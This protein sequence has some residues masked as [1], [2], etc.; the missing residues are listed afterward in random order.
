MGIYKSDWDRV[1]GFPESYKYGW[2]GE[3][4][5]LMD[6]VFKQGLEYIR[7]KCP[8]V[9]HYNHDRKKMWTR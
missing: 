1:G 5:D 2:G 4:Y 3:D 7:I 9:Y 8:Y 6:R